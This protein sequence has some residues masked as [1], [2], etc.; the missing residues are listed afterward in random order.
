MIERFVLPS[1]RNISP[2]RGDKVSVSRSQQDN[3]IHPI[4]LRDL[5][6]R[7]PRCTAISA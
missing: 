4:P 3:L 5:D 1:V 6:R 7:T 2:A